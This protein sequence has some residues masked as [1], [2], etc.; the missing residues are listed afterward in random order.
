MKKAFAYLSVASVMFLASC[1]NTEEAP[2]EEIVEP[3]VAAY[4]VDT[5]SS[6]IKWHGYKTYNPDYGH[7]GTVSLTGGTVNTTDGTITSASF[8]V[9]LNTITT[10]DSLPEGKAAMLDGHLKAADFFAVDSLGADVKFDVTSYENG[11]MKGEMTMMGLT[12]EVEAA[13][14]VEMTEGVMMITG[15]F[16]LDLGIF[17]AP[18][19]QT[20]V[21]EEG[22][23]M[24]DE[25]KQNLLNPGV[26]FVVSIKATENK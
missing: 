24:D 20:P 16:A 15:E 3:V 12:K 9:D 14:T 5:E 10:T 11:V 26:N 17:G 4:S 7:M 19:L 23:E 6:S 8:T 13:T 1:G 18:Y 21:M 22:V 2:K 25:M